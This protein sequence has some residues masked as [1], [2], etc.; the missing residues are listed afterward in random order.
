M[1][2]FESLRASLS[3]FDACFWCLGISSNGMTEED[4]TRITYDY[5][6]AAA[7]VLVDI[8]PKMTFVFISGVNAERSSSRMW[9]RVKARA[10]DD[11]MKLPFGAVYV[12]RP[13]FVEP[14]DGIRSRTPLYNRLYVVMK[15]LVPLIKLIFAS[16][17]SSTRNIGRAMIA[18]ATRGYEKTLLFSPDFNLLA[19]V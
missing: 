13:G 17:S 14:L 7:R 18:L 16:N 5:T 1:L 2:E 10:E 8:N 3:G 11:L 9:A 6:M 15:P 19:G 4:Y 12:M